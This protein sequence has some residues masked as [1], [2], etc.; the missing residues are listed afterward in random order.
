MT[1]PATMM[2]YET[3]PPAGLESSAAGVQDEVISA[4]GPDYP[5]YD[6]PGIVAA[7]RAAINTHLPDGVILGG[8]DIFYGPDPEGEVDLAAAIAAVNLTT[9]ASRY[10]LDRQ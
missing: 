6:I 7:Y 4:L 8:N 9:L 3:W 1:M 2:I 10:A 5:D